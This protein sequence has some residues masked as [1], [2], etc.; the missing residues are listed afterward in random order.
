MAGVQKS[1]TTPYHPMGN[2]VTE[3]F[4]RTLGNMLR[5]LPSTAKA[6]WPQ[7]L[8]TVTFC[9][10][11][12]VHETTGLAPFYVMFGRVPR[13]PVD[14]MFQHVLQNDDVISH[15]EFVSRLRKDL[16]DASQIAQNHAFHEQARHARLY[17]RKVKGSPL[18]VGDRVLLANRGE[19]GKRKLADKWDPT[20]YDVVS[21]RS[22]LNVYRIRESHTGKERVVH[23]N[24]LLPV[25]FL[26]LGVEGSLAS[27]ADLDGGNP[28]SGDDQGSVR[29]TQM[30]HHDRT[31]DWL[32]KTP[33]IQGLANDE[34]VE[35][36]GSLCDVDPSSGS[37]AAEDPPPEVNAE[38]FENS[39]SEFPL[40]APVSSDAALRQGSEPV[41]VAPVVPMADVDLDLA[42][43]TQPQ[44]IQAGMDGLAITRY[45]RSVRP[46][47]RL[48]CEMAAQKVE[49]TSSV[50]GSVFAFLTSM[51]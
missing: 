39:I 15:H 41:A 4:N 9:Y 42:I 5:T 33:E 45:G 29:S 47:K 46:P 17:N 21:V 6:R 35:V 24:L 37:I 48:I 32:L 3:R 11:C 8:R 2:G 31:L 38:V 34:P 36:E 50:S 43:C 25:N 44:S 30:D 13:L 19:R 40:L 22:G 49:E 10:N 16:F 1:H 51:F 20:P 27:R 28:N 7:M 14:M 12:T 26:G 18:A 23:R